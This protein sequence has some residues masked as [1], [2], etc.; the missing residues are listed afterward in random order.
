VTNGVADP[1]SYFQDMRRYTSAEPAPSIKCPSLVTDNEADLVSTAQGQRLYDAMTCK[2]TFR[3]FTRA[4]GAEGIA[5]AW[6]V[7]LNWRYEVCERT[8]LNGNFG[9]AARG[10]GVCQNAIEAWSAPAHRAA[11]SGRSGAWRWP[12]TR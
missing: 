10:G 1:Q 11:M 8:Y 12:H 7:S 3:R 2:T 9:S 5:K 6:K 4:E